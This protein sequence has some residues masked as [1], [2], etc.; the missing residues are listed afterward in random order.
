MNGNEPFVLVFGRSVGAPSAHVEDTAALVIK[1]QINPLHLLDFP[2]SKARV[3][4][5]RDCDLLDAGGSSDEQFDLLGRK[6][7]L[8]PGLSHGQFRSDQT[9]LADLP[10]GVTPLEYL[11]ADHQ[12]R[13]DRLRLIFLRHEPFT[14]PIE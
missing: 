12:G 4:Q 8:R 14:I 5:G 13:V 11:L 2:N 1:A 7:R 10:F 9:V 6:A 3:S